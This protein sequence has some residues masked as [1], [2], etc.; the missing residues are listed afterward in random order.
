[1]TRMMGP[2][3]PP[4]D[5]ESEVEEIADNGETGY[6]LRGLQGR[7]IRTIGE[8]VVRGLYPPDTLLP[9]ESELMERYSASRTSVRE[10]IKVLSAK[11]LVETRQK[12]G[13]RVRARDQWNIFDADVLAWHDFNEDGDEILKDLIEM[14]QIVEPPAARF[15]AGR[16]TLDD[17]AAIEA[18]WEAMHK[19]TDDPAAYTRAD[20]AF[21][22][23]VF[24][25]SHNVLLKRF[26]HI[27]GN[28]LQISF[29][30]QQEA[31]VGAEERLDEDV[32]VH[33]EIFQAINRGD[34]PAAEAAMMRTILDGK[35]HL[36][37]ARS[38]FRDRLRKSR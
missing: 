37:K 11:G 8:S 4:P 3:S 1:M 13:T 2:D 21:H 32:A 12:I 17:I 22:M 15:A 24:R 26:A 31:L 34:P 18:A 36:Q 23:A 5:I 33:F 16:A 38:R 28:F 30:I 9:R 6:R 27:V 7:L 29:R 14:R 19:A 10:A 25:A 20:V 35:T